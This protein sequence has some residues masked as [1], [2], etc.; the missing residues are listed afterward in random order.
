MDLFLFVLVL[1]VLVL[2]HEL[3][4]FTVAKAFGIPIEEFGIGFPPRIAT[5]F[6]WKGTRFTLNAIPFGGFVRPKGDP[7]AHTHDALR[8]APGWQQFLVIL[9]GPAVNLVIAVGLYWVMFVSHG[10]PV[11]KSIVVWYVE[12]D[13]PAWQAGMQP[14]DRI[15]AVN[16]IPVR[17]LDTLHNLVQAHQGEVMTVTVARGEGTVTL[18]VLARRNPPPDQ[19]PMGIRIV[20]Y[21]WEPVSAGQA[22]VHAVGTTWAYAHA[23]FRFPVDLIMAQMGLRPAPQGELLGF[24]GIYTSLKTAFLADTMLGHRMPVYTL[25]L[26]AGL[27]LSFGVLNLFPVPML[28]GGRLVII[29]G[30]GLARRRLPVQWEYAI[31]LVSFFLLMAL[32]LVINL[33]EWL[34]Q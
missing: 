11:E 26:V 6:T 34:P 27:S 21:G 19:G 20:P 4:H 29:L 17:D 2:L 14:R 16:G 10:L 23:L 28:D 18:R 25:S 7:Q 30:E 24:R 1:G 5:L 3:G 13:S 32:M 12:P 22:V 15:L 33:R 31:M 9:A 8:R